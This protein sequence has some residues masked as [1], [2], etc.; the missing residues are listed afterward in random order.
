MKEIVGDLSDLRY[1]RTDDE[2]QKDTV[3]QLML[4]LENLQDEC[5]EMSKT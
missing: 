5:D 4:G 2:N 3:E 1:G